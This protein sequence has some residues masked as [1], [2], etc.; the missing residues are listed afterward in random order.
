MEK[1]CNTRGG[2][3]RACDRCGRRKDQTLTQ[4]PPPYGSLNAAHP[5]LLCNKCNN[6]LIRVVFE[7]MG[8]PEPELAPY[9]E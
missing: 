9:G 4:V 5:L 3:Y 7:W 6:D 8:L 1:T 2:Y